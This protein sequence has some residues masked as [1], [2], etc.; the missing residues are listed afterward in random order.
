MQ[1]DNG[2]AVVYTT[3][4]YGEAALLRSLLESSGITC[5][6][7][8]EASHTTAKFGLH[9]IVPIRLAVPA[10]QA[11]HAADVIK[12]AMKDKR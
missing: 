5:L 6:M 4:N 2:P 10:S 8:D 7:M 3:D 1:E 11:A 12:E 9:A